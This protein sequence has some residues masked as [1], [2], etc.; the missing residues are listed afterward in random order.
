M[1][2]ISENDGFGCHVCGEGI[3]HLY[4]ILAREKSL[5]LTM[6]LSLFSIGKLYAANNSVP[7]QALLV[8]KGNKQGRNT[9]VG[10]SL[11]VAI[12]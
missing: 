12:V 1:L 7:I 9:P 5:N 4:L 10:Q 3:L 2:R 6:Q 11:D 8:N